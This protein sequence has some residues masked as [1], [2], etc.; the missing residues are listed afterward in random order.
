[1][2]AM[3]YESRLY[4]PLVIEHIDAPL[5]S[6]IDADGNFI[7][8]A[9]PLTPLALLSIDLDDWVGARAAETGITWLLKLRS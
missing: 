8:A 1:M 2:I 3:S 5:R 9:R 7:E 6:P 4:G